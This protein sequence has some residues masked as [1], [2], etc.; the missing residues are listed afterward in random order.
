MPNQFGHFYQSI[1]MKSLVLESNEIENAILSTMTG[2]IE[3][4]QTHIDKAL[5]I[6]KSVNNKM[7]KL[8]VKVTG[9][10]KF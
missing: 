5:T 10:N 4:A 1:E 6:K 2:D 7:M 8:Y 3:Q 9:K